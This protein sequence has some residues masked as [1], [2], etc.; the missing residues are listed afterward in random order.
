MTTAPGQVHNRY[1]DL[2]CQVRMV[3][4][5]PSEASYLFTLFNFLKRVL[6]TTECEN[7]APS[8][9]CQDLNSRHLGHETRSMTTT[10]NRASKFSAK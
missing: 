9:P 2:C 3:E 1:V 7:F 6:F 10:C 4:L 5:S 8:L